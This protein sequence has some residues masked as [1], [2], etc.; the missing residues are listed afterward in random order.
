ME[1]TEP[2][3]QA[4]KII[5]RESHEI[6]EAEL[7]LDAGALATERGAQLLGPREQVPRLGEELAPVGREREAAGVMA[8]EE[9]GAENALEMGDRG[10]DRG[11]GHVE[12]SRS[13]GDVA[14][15]G[16]GREIGE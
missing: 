2:A 4:R 16:G 9:L 6:A 11:L 15:L 14:A 10:R 13:L 8:Q 12:H 3:Q 5:G 7:A 1:R